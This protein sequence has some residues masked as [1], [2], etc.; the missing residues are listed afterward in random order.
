MRG[1][2]KIKGKPNKERSCS[3]KMYYRHLGNCRK[4]FCSFC[5]PSLAIRLEKKEAI[6]D[7]I[8]YYNII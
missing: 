6:K 1:R 5:R 4:G 3:E 8:K 7:E 2:T